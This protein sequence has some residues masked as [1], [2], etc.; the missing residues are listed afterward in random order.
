MKKVEIYDQYKNVY[1]N[2]GATL[3]HSSSGLTILEAEGLSEAE[4]FSKVE[5]L[6]NLSKT[7]G[8]SYED[9][10]IKLESGYAELVI[11]FDDKRVLNRV[12]YT[13]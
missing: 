1:D 12:I 9:K 8:V 13:A 5:E 10:L 3:L 7:I 6:Y 4:A 11:T 2:D